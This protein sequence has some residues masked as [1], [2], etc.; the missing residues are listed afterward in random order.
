[1]LLSRL[2]PFAIETFG[3]LGPNALRL[4]RSA[5][6][7]LVESEESV[8][9]WAGQALFQRWLAQISCELQRSNFEAVSAAWGEQAR[10]ELLLPACLPFARAA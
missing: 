8:R 10:S 5:W 6:Q 2:H 9:G 4:L 3:R 1:M 7:R